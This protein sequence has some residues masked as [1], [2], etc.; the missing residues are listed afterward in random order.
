MG[1]IDTPPGNLHPKLTGLTQAQEQILQQQ[2]QGLGWETQEAWG[3][4]D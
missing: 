4:S 1:N 3:C 2:S